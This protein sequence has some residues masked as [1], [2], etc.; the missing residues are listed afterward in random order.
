M[1][2]WGL[3]FL[4]LLVAAAAAV[5]FWLYEPQQQALQEA[6][7]KAAAAE[8]E[9]ASLRVRVAD[10][11]AIRDRLQKAS[12]DLQQVVSEK[13]KE[14]TALHSTQD[15]L[16]DG[17]QKEIADKQIEVERIRDQIRVQMVDEILFDSGEAEIKP[18]GLEVLKRVGAVLKK[19]EG[20]NIEVQGY[21]D[22][23]P[24]VGALA[25][26]FPTNWELS[27]ARAT[28][29]ARFLTEE[30]GVDPRRI[31][32]AAYSEYRPR[33]TNETE[34][35]RRRNRRIEILLG[36]LVPAGEPAGEG[37]AGAAAKPSPA[38]G[39]KDATPPQESAA[40]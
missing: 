6:R 13:E 30:T 26:R 15:E 20:R 38:A 3:A 1:A 14:L 37:D 11:E 4:V 10:L 29:V 27:A 24:I 22:N 36:P 21:T 17:L 32:A 19:T 31:S 18:A 16:V 34:A 12:E 7:D 40:P 2:K 33:D 25:R 23:V 5:W 8:R 28:N 39:A 9:V 35:G